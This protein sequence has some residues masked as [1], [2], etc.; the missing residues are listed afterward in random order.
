[1]KKPLHLIFN[2]HSGLGKKA[3]TLEMIRESLSKDFIVTEYISKSRE[4]AAATA[5]TICSAEPRPVIAIAGGDG[6]LSD[7]LNGCTVSTVT[8]GIIPTGTVNIVAQE[9]KLPLDIPAACRII[10]QGAIRRIDIPTANGRRFMFGAGIGFDAEIVHNVTLETKLRLGKMSYAL[11]TLRTMRRFKPFETA[12]TVD[13]SAVYRGT[14]YTVIIGKSKL[15]A[16]KYV[17]FP[18]AAMDNGVLD[19]AVFHHLSLFKFASGCLKFFLKRPDACITLARGTC[20]EVSPAGTIPVQID[21]DAEG[22]SPVT[23]RIAEQQLALF[24]PVS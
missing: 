8:L 1:M 15:Y 14:A 7:V 24:A 10:A 3:G 12:V 20:V 16:G 9:L 18:E 11:E 4:Q 13:G 2:P 5:Q 19:V 21:G 17:L 6:T 22:F 23:F